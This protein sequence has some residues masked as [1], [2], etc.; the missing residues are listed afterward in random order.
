[1]A[2]AAQPGGRPGG[3]PQELLGPAERMVEWRAGVD[4]S[5]EDQLA[6]AAHLR[7]PVLVLHG[8]AD[9][10]VPIADSRRLATRLPTRVRLVEF[11]GAGHTES[12]QSDPA[13]YEAVVRAFLAP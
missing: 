8:T 5:E 4:L 9:A 6:H 10:V 11:P 2:P 3:A 7:A 1:M 13:Q 12:W